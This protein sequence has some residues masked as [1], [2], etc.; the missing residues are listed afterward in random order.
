[1]F[2]FL[3]L[4]INKIWYRHCNPMRYILN[5]LDFERAEGAD[6]GGKKVDDHCVFS[7]NTGRFRGWVELACG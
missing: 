2:L 7:Q 4:R 5:K 6:F 1:M 3:S